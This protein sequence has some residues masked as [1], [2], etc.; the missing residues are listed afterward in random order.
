MTEE[1]KNRVVK[2]FSLIELLMIIM[3][4]G[5]IFTLII[6]ISRDNKRR[7]LLEEAMHNVQ[8]IKYHNELFKNNPDLGDGDYAGDIEQLNLNFISEYIEPVYFTY[9]LTDTTIVAEI[10]DAFAKTQSGEDALKVVYTLPG[11]PWTVEGGLRAESLINPD[12]SP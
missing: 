8:V 4:V 9:S 5:I 6:P 2:K 1:T 11:G 3:V 12:W 10:T 7:G